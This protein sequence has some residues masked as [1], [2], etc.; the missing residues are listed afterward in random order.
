MPG[1]LLNDLKYSQNDFTGLRLKRGTIL[2]TELTSQVLFS[3]LRKSKTIDPQFGI[4]QGV[5]KVMAQKNGG[6]LQL[7]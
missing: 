2:C 1:D 7:T 3:F 6:K 4:I 5:P